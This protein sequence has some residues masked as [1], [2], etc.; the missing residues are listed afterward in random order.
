MVINDP[1]HLNLKAG[2]KFGLVVSHCLRMQ[3]TA[4][5]IQSHYAER[6]PKILYGSV[7][8]K[9]QR[10]ESPDRIGG[11]LYITEVELAQCKTDAQRKVDA[12]RSKM[13]A[14]LRDVRGS[15]RR[16]YE[17]RNPFEERKHLSLES[18][19]KDSRRGE[20]QLSVVAAEATEA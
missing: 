16:I 8:D 14:I 20:S 13:R 7:A 19:V 2:S 5:R 3:S 10:V 6:A 1:R 18:Q 17:A 11:K 4:C 12:A 9:W 15:P